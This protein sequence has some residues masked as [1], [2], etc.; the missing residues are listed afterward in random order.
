MD[1]SRNRS[2]LWIGRLAG[3]CACA[4]AA[5]S[6]VSRIVRVGRCSMKPPEGSK[7][8]LDVAALRVAA[9][10]ECV[11]EPGLLPEGEETRIRLEGGSPP[12]ER[13]APH[14]AQ[15]S[16]CHPGIGRHCAP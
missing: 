8:T 6:R 14:E 3:D 7:P 2:L 16:L 13:N 1:R 5:P 9:Q 15:A 4:D 11:A 10:G 12:W